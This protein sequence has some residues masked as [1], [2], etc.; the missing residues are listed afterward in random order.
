[1]KNPE[2]QVPPLVGSV[3]IRF[4][5]NGSDGLEGWVSFVVSNSIK[6][7]NVAVRRGSDGGFYLT[8]PNRIN[9]RGAKHNLFHPISTQASE[10]IRDAVL[11]RLASLA[12]AA[13]TSEPEEPQAR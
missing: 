3:S 10:A 12:K 5:E 2:T 7:N 6:L 13:A 9:S 11:T 1:M 8:Y 4:V